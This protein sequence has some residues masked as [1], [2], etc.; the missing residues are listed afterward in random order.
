MKILKAKSFLNHVE[1]I[2]FVSDNKIEKED[3][4]VITQGG[5]SDFSIFFYSDSEVKEKER[6]FWGKLED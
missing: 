5:T 3:I 2:R 4:F 1:L 6:N